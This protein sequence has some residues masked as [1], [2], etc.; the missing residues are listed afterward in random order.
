MPLLETLLS[1]RRSW[2][3]TMAT[4][5]IRAAKGGRIKAVESFPA[6]SEAYAFKKEPALYEAA[7]EGHLQVVKRLLAAGADDNAAYK[8]G[9]HKAAG[10]GHPE[11]VKPLLAAKADVNAAN[12]DGATALQI[13]T[14]QGH[15]DVV[16]Q[17]RKAGGK[18]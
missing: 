3:N 16:K 18:M 14:E 4:A 12:N 9:L 15:R 7:T 17:L 13:A 5:L 11:V 6:K 2:K 1:L 10:K 8:D